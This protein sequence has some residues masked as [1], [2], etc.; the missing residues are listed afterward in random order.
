MVHSQRM[1][2]HHEFHVCSQILMDNRAH[3]GK[4]KISLQNQASIK[5]CKEPNVSGHGE[6]LVVDA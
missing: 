2:I 6:C 4:V 5:E 3:S 1:C